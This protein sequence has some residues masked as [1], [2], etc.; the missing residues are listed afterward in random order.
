MSG[1]QWNTD[2]KMIRGNWEGINQQLNLKK[3]VYKVENLS[4]A[5]H[6]D[7]VGGDG[8]S[9]HIGFIH[10]KCEK[11][12]EGVQ[13][14]KWSELSHW[15]RENQHNQTPWKRSSPAS[16]IFPSL[17]PKRP[18]RDLALEYCIHLLTIENRQDVV[19]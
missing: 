6:M 15:R 4:S 19:L 12:F 17:R 5:Q 7:Q 10:E 11:M 2:E 8:T 14:I 1:P 3:E 16:Y 9:V 13:K 18:R